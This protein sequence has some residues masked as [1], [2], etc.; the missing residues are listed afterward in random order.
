LKRSQDKKKADLQ[1]KKAEKLAQLA[2]E[3]AK[4]SKGV[5][6]PDLLRSSVASAGGQDVM[7]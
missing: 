1:K 6:A 7:F 5:E 2:A 3:E 4:A